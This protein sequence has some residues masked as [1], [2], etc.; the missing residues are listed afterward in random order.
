MQPELSSADRSS[1]DRFATWSQNLRWAFCASEWSICGH[2]WVGD[3]Y[4]AAGGLLPTDLERTQECR[5]FRALNIPKA[6]QILPRRHRR[7]LSPAGSCSTLFGEYLTDSLALQGQQKTIQ[8]CQW[9]Q[10][11]W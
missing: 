9:R 7:V 1:P 11:R 3:A 8:C 10:S 5:Y 4:K 2:L 6:F